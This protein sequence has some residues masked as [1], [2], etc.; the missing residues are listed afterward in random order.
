MWRWDQGRLLYFQ[1]DVLC[2]MAKALLKFDNV[3]ISRCEQLFRTTLTNETGMPFLP[4]HYTIRRNYSRVFQCSFL[5]NFY[6]NNGRL[7][8]TDICKELATQEGNIKTAD[9]YLFNYIKRFRF[10]FPAFDN[11]N[12]VDT[13][14]YP[15]CAILK[16]LLAKRE[17]G[18][19]A[20]ASLE[21]IFQYIIGN[22][23]TGMEDISYY[24]IL[25]KSGYVYTD[26]ERRQ[27]R[28]M[29]IF[30]SQLSILKTYNDHLY[31]D[32][33]SDAVKDEVLEKFLNPENRLPKE[34]KFDEF[35]EMTSAGHRLI[36]PNLEI[37]MTEQE[38]REFIEGNRKRI[39]HF[40]I[41][42]SSVL[43]KYYR[44]IH[45]C[46]ICCACGVDVRKRYPWTD[47]MLDIHHLLPLSSSAA[48]STR[49]TSLVDIVGICPSCHR[50]VHIY[51]SKW[52][53]GHNQS[54]FTSKE[55]AR[56]VF[57]Q[58]TEEISQ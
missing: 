5:A 21:D 51:Y 3:D 44:Q 10:P 37:S 27:L 20:K 57:V 42:R 19:E 55:E 52:L 32:D 54:D 24:K 38:D 23:C 13:R 58:A 35:M 1:F 53:Q 50:A 12:A 22:N 56:E 9:D 2:L 31:L 7:V 26:T 49:G 33:I 17:K 4:E 39:E 30:I 41:E 14:V 6:S 25:S 43:R 11:Y 18:E 47:Y 16:Y 34:N 46:P 45:P 48:I 28:E 15:F 8:V 29:I 40:R 36:I